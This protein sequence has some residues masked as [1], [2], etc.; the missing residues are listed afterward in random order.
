MGTMFRIRALASRKAWLQREFT[1]MARYNRVVA[2]E[3]RRNGTE[4]Y[5]PYWAVQEAK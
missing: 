3:C 2:Y 1:G 5:T 4:S